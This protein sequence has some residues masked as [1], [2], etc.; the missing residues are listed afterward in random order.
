MLELQ[1]GSWDVEGGQWKQGLMPTPWKHTTDP[2]QRLPPDL[3]FVLTAQ[4]GEKPLSGF[5]A[6]TAENRCQLVLVFSK[7][8][9]MNVF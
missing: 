6:G 8:R 9:F 7:G 3:V 1:A 4:R 5:Q 2:L